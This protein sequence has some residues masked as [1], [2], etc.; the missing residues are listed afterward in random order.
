MSYSHA[1]SVINDKI[2][3]DINSD[4]ESKLKVAEERVNAMETEINKPKQTLA[5]VSGTLAKE[6]GQD[7][8]RDE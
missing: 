1:S 6:L 5:I 4:L 2:I 7:N 8:G 3:D